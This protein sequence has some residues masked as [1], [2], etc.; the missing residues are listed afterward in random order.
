MKNY[1]FYIVLVLVFLLVLVS[2]AGCGTVSIKELQDN[3]NKYLGKEITVR[4]TAENAIKIGSL[5]GF[6]LREG[7]YS[8][9]V[10]S[11]AL[12][13]EGEIVTVKGTLMKELIIG[14]YIYA[15]KIY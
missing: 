7:N 3:P 2:A 13:A 11:K 1:N 8:I 10:S 4:G 14:Y 5:S 9:A 6:S 12:P 15:N